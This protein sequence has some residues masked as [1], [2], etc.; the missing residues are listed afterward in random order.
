MTFIAFLTDIN[1]IL[2]C[3]SE[4]HCAITTVDVSLKDNKKKLPHF[5]H[6]SEMSHMKKHGSQ[7]EVHII[8]IKKLLLFFCICS[9][10]ILLRKYKKLSIQNCLYVW[11][12]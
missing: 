12:E 7:G 9:S 1:I 3:T 6:T 4:R 8:C 5:V 10:A 11:K 2:S